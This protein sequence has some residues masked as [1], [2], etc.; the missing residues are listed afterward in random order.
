MYFSELFTSY[1]WLFRRKILFST[2]NSSS[3][4]KWYSD[5]N[6]ILLHL[7]TR[8]FLWSLSCSH[9]V[10]SSPKIQTGNLI[11]NQWLVMKLRSVFVF[12]YSHNINYNGLTKKP[13]RVTNSAWPS[14]R[15]IYG[16][17]PPHFCKVYNTY[18]SS[19]STHPTVQH[20]TVVSS[21]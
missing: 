2:N 12:I 18:K 21:I 7:R 19:K 5:E 11:L 4:K 14:S 9:T 16:P 15:V 17:R 3:T 13:L 8:H 6:M 10:Y 1:T 20:I